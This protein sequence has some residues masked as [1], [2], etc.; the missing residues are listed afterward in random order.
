MRPLMDKL[1]EGMLPVSAWLAPIHRS[2]RIR[3]RRAVEG[4]VLAVALHRQLLQVRWKAFQVL[5]V[6]QD[7]DRFRTEEIGIP[8]AEQ[9]HEHRQVAVEWRGP[10]ML[11][12]LVET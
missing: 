2:S 9:P 8:D 5:L 6:R 7:G 12:H 10:E 1:I 3:H 4:D 11:V